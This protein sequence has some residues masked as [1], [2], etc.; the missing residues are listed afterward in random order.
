MSDAFGH[1]TQHMALHIVTMNV[2]APLAALFLRNIQIRPLDMLAGWLAPAAVFQLALLWL[3]H[4]PAVFEQIS[5]SPAISATTH[6]ALL[7]SAFVFWR[8]VIR[9]APTSPW[10]PIG[11]LL[12]TGKIVCLL[13]VLLLFAGRPLYALP[14]AQGPELS[15]LADQQLAGLLMLIGCPLTYVFGATIV[16]SRWLLRMDRPDLAPRTG[17]GAA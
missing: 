5:R 9:L 10:R 6:V 8:E 15:G 17:T 11:A 4:V 12:I 3:M 13:G 16:A 1:V 14:H 2:A 7:A